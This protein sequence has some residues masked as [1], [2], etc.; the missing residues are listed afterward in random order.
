MRFSSMSSC[1]TEE[2]QKSGFPSLRAKLGER[3]GSETPNHIFL[4][5]VSPLKGV[6]TAQQPQLT[7]I[8]TAFATFAASLVFTRGSHRV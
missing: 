7:A 1:E 5:V 3:L 6:G 2:S 8:L 4:P